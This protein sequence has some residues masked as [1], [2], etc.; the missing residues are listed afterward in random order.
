MHMDSGRLADGNQRP[1][2]QGDVRGAD[3][4]TVVDGN[5]NFFNQ[6]AFSDPGDQVPGNAPRYFADLRSPRDQ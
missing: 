4:L 6:S 2:V 3:V 5:G 1:N